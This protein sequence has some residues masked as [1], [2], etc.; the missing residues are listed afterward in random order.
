MRP[1]VYEAHAED[2][3]MANATPNVVALIAFLADKVQRARDGAAQRR[4][5]ADAFECATPGE[6]ETGRRLMMAHGRI[7]GVN[8]FTEAER[9]DK[10]AHDRIVA[11]RL[12]DE[13]E[14]LTAVIGLLRAGG[15]R[16]AYLRE[17]ESDLVG[18]LVDEPRGFTRTA[19]D[20]QLEEVRAVL[21]SA[22]EVAA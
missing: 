11:Q 9:A 20:A 10:V 4:H 5:M 16:E 17:R 22:D 3:V 7:T 13:A 2:G 1:S 15:R 14:T 18:A 21:K 19:Y 8:P 6:L 12:E